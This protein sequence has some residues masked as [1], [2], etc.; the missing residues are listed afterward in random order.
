[1]KRLLA[2]AALCTLVGACAA[3]APQVVL[4]AA[5]PPGEPGNIAGLNTDQIKIAFGQPA[6]VRDDNGTQMWRYDGAACKAFFFFYPANNALTVKHVETLPRGAVMA[7]DS[8]CLASLE[9]K[10]AVPTT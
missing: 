3:P 5:P 10:K 7:A 1:M 8:N 6:F 9:V 4:P 2:A